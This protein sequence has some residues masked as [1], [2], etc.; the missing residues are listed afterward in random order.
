[1]GSRVNIRIG[2]PPMYEEIAAAFPHVSERFGVVYTWGDTI[3]NPSGVQ[4]PKDLVA[5]EE[6][7]MKQQADDPAGWWRR[8]IAN[9]EF[10]LSQ[11]VAAY[12]RQYKVFC[13]VQRDKNLRLRKLMT[14]SADL[15]SPIYGFVI[16]RDRAMREIA[17][18]R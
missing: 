3:Y 5:H 4:L 11:E 6:V 9:A 13:E 15:A 7:H 18:A 16:T 14:L 12:Q 1:M 2:L 17:N 8:Y 10:R